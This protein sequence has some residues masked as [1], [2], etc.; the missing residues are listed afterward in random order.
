MGSQSFLG[1]LYYTQAC[2]GDQAGWEKAKACFDEVYNK[3]VY[4]LQPKFA[5]LFV[6]N[7]TG[8]KESIFS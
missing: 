7:V 2:Q 1:K 8:S 5:D 6:N 3:G 4:G